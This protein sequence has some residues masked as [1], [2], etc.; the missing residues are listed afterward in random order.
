[1]IE[2]NLLPEEL[3]KKEPKF[4]KIDLS[5]INV[6][7]IPI[8]KIAALFFAVLVIIQVILVLIGIYGNSVVSS[9]SK[10]YSAIS[11]KKAEAES[12]KSQVDTINR[13]V[14]AI[15]ELMVKRFSWSKKLNDLSDSMTP[16]IWLNEVSYDEKVTE[17]A[18][19]QDGRAANNKSRK[20]TSK[21]SPEKI[22]SRYLILSGYASSMGEEGTALIGKFIKSLKD[23][24][25][26][27]S[28]F[29]TIELGVI[30]RDRVE[31]QEVM[32][33]KITCL[34]KEEK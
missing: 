17:R 18:S 28:D 20:D 25:S 4:K 10:D 9:L 22:L 15:D 27:Y 2:I 11:P 24:P 14:N 8:L 12:L 34:F 1:M 31:D 32:N 13:K 30:K 26:F 19:Q 33:F 3:K 23:N 21:A 6:Q 29:S 7:D 5:G 16:G